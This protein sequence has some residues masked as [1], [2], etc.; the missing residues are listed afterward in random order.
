MCYM[1]SSFSDILLTPVML[2]LTLQ[3]NLMCR[4]GVRRRSVVCRNSRDGMVV[5][6]TMCDSTVR[7]ADTMSCAAEFPNI[8]L[9]DPVWVPEEWSPVSSYCTHNI[10]SS[11]IVCSLLLLFFVSS[12]CNIEITINLSSN[13]L[14][15]CTVLKGLWRWLALQASQMY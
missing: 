4:D 13:S 9:L 5:P 7:P 1:I 2:I 10:N 11:K 3:C 14:V 15:C 6:D 8:C 12:Y